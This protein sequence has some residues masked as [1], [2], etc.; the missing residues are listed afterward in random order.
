M[1]VSDS[2]SLRREIGAQPAVLATTVLEELPVDDKGLGGVGDGAGMEVEEAQAPGRARGVLRIDG[3]A[4]APRRS[5]NPLT[6]AEVG[7]RVGDG[8]DLTID[9]GTDRL[10]RRI[11]FGGDDVQ[12]E[13]GVVRLCVQAAAV[14]AGHL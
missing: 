4:R 12:G 5:V 14:A 11:S 7:G 13:G 2:G 1:A 3:D 6:L 10:S 8:D 9:G